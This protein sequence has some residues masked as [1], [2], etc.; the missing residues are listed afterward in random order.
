MVRATK[1]GCP[2]TT[3]V[4]LSSKNTCARGNL[5]AVMTK[6]GASAASLFVMMWI[7]SAAPASAQA[8]PT[9]EPSTQECPDLT[10]TYEARSTAWIDSFHLQATGTVRPKT[11]A[12]PFATFQRR[13]GGYTLIWHAP[14]E[15]VLAAARS[16]AQQDPRKYGF[17]LDYVLRD[18]QLPLPVG[19]SEQEW[20]NRI[21]NV[22]PV[23][24][25]DVVLPLR[26][27]KGGW[28]LLATMG[29]NGPADEAGG[30]DGTRD[31]AL[32][33]GREKDGS[34]SLKLEERRKQVIIDGRYFNEVAIPLWSSTRLDK[35][36]S[37]PKPDLTPIRADELPDGNRPSKRIPKCQITSDHETVFIHRLKANLPPKAEITQYSAT[38]P[39]GRM[40]ADGV[41]DPTSYYVTISAPD[42]AGIAKVADYLRTDPFIRQID[43]QESQVLSNGLLIVKFRMMAAP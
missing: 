30:M 10:G 16:Q 40:R 11:Q 7:G 43:A 8:L 39:Y 26:Q 31:A 19:V 14:R 4:H 1:F 33:L 24:R 34:L 2:P 20:F 37:T 6:A 25:V 3:G 41:C 13:G 42:A 36:P 22:G 21:A 9:A 27:C 35:W 15:D 28:F 18:P 23:F 12:R 17:W 29:R 32:W 38:L 5:L